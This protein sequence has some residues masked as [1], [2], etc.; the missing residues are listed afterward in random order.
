MISWGIAPSAI[1]TRLFHTARDVLGPL[2]PIR[3]Q[4]QGGTELCNRQN[5]LSVLNYRREMGDNRWHITAEGLS[6]DHGEN[7]GAK[8]CRWTAE[9]F[10]VPHVWRGQISVKSIMKTMVSKQRAFPDYSPECLVK[11]EERKW[12]SSALFHKEGEQAG[13]MRLNGDKCAL[14]MSTGNRKICSPLQ[15]SMCTRGCTFGWRCRRKRNRSHSHKDTEAKV[16]FRGNNSEIS[17]TDT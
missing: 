9:G 11:E 15:L 14:T 10:Q 7:W 8:G 1:W 13:F 17:T 6:W 2:C 4:H 12:G 5:C 16:T 3:H